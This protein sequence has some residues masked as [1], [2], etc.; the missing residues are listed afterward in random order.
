MFLL[1]APAPGR[2]LAVRARQALSD[3]QRAVS[4]GRFQ[5]AGA[6]LER[7]LSES[8]DDSDPTDT[9]QEDE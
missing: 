3:Y 5:D 8:G 7:I 2:A 6:A 4:D 9:T 1:A